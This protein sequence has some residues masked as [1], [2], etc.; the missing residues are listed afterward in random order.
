MWGELYRTPFTIPSPAA[1]ST[2]AAAFVEGEGEEGIDAGQHCAPPRGV[3]VANLR[4]PQQRR[5]AATA[6]PTT[7]RTRVFG[8][9]ASISGGEHRIVLVLGK[10]MVVVRAAAAAVLA[11]TH[12]HP[13]NPDTVRA[14]L[15]LVG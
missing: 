1:S 15:L 11:C 10:V 14:M 4:G 9:A 6:P 7:T 2:T 5:R 8:G 12:P 3:N 13:A